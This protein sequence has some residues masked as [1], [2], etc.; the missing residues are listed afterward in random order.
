M[1]GP[2]HADRRQ[3]SDLVATEPPARATLP[4]IEPAAAPTACIRVVI[5]D[6]IDLILGPQLA[7]GTLMPRL[8]ASPA[9][10]TL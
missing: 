3:L 8:T 1:L 10:L 4:V 5:D 2:P 6:P 7:A 9:A